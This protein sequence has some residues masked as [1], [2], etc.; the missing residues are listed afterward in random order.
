[1][2]V[3]TV[4]NPRKK[5]GDFGDIYCDV[6]GNNSSAYIKLSTSMPHR[7]Y[8]AHVTIVCKGCLFKWDRLINKTILDDVVKKGIERR[9]SNV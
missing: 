9:D 6:C 5:N 3:E 2:N 1:M 8:E 4:N 7:P